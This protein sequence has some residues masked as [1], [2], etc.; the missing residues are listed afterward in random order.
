MLLIERAFNR[1][2]DYRVGKVTDLSRPP[3]TDSSRTFF[4]DTSLVQEVRVRLYRTSLYMQ[5]RLHAFANAL[6]RFGTPAQLYIDSSHPLHRRTHRHTGRHDICAK[7]LVKPQFEA[8]R[9][10][11]Y[12]SF[13][14]QSSGNHS[15]FCLLSGAL[16][17]STL[18]LQAYFVIASIGAGVFQL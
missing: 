12:L 7:L 15:G 4:S 14:V 8:C 17:S 11:P 16:D 6:L 3:A 13:P 1:T 5:T 2:A 18:P 9:C 10:S